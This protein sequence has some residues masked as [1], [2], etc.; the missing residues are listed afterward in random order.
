MNIRQK[1]RI[2]KSASLCLPNKMDSLVAGGEDG[3]AANEE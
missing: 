3:L 1:I 2:E